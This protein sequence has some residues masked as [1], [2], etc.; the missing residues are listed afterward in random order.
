MVGILIIFVGPEGLVV[1]KRTLKELSESFY[2]G[3]FQVVEIS[4]AKLC[5]L[6]RGIILKDFEALYQYLK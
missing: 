6:S 1:S 4:L 5:R 3:V 2:R